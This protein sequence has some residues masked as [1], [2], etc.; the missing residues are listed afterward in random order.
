MRSCLVAS[1]VPIVLLG[2]SSSAQVMP[3]TM[4]PFAGTAAEDT[5]R[6]KTSYPIGQSDVVARSMLAAMRLEQ[7]Q[8]D[9]CWELGC[10]VIVNES[11][12]YV[13][14]GFHVQERKRD[15]S[16]GWSGNQF[17]APLLSKRATFRFKT[18]DANS[19]AQ[20]VKFVLRKPHTKDTV[21]FETRVPLCSSPHQDSLVR[22]RAVI[23]EVE[24]GS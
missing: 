13:V 10:V 11:S 2:T 20:P 22:I 6:P 3:V 24:V 12:S 19:C 17:G 1:L 7:R 8:R 5:I 21:Q 18:G 23:P 15:G 14:T 16:L 9:L 4:D